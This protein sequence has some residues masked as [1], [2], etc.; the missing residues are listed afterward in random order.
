MNRLCEPF[1]RLV[2]VFFYGS[3]LNKMSEGAVRQKG[4]IMDT[5]VTIATFSIL[6][7]VIFRL[8]E[9]EG[10]IKE[11]ESE[12]DDYNLKSI[13]VVKTEVSSADRSETKTPEDSSAARSVSSIPEEPVETEDVVVEKSNAEIGAEEID[14]SGPFGEGGGEEEEEEEEE[15]PQPPPRPQRKTKRSNFISE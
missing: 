5:L 9:A 4:S 14:A 1:V 12:L 8:F 11:I 7:V 3:T 6:G 2:L 15:P 10:R 13:P